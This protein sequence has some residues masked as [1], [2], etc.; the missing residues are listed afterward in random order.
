MKMLSAIIVGKGD[1]ERSFVPTGDEKVLVSLSHE[2]AVSGI[3]RDIS[4]L[5]SN[6]FH[7]EH[8]LPRLKTFLA[9]QCISSFVGARLATSYSNFLSLFDYFVKNG[10][11]DM[12]KELGSSGMG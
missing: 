2:H 6:S 4:E 11:G 10:N 9:S 5:F 7:L 3:R 1:F 12:N 8:P